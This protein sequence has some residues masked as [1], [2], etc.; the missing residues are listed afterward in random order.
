MVLPS[1]RALSHSGAEPVAAENNKVKLGR[2]ELIQPWASAPASIHFEN[3]KGF[4]H[5]VRCVREITVSHWGNIYFEETF[6]LHNAG[7]KHKGAFSRLKYQYGSL[8][9]ANSF[10]A[11]R[12]HLPAGAHSLYYKDLIG[13]ISSSN[14]RKASN[15]AGLALDLEPRYPLMGGWKVDFFVGYSLPLGNGVLARSSKS[16][17]YRLSLP[18]SAAM[19][20]VSID[21]LVVRVVLP[22]GAASIKAELPFG[23]VEQGRDKVFSYLDTVGRPVLVLTKRGMVPEHMGAEMVVEYSFS[24]SALWR[25]GLLLVAAFATLFALLIAT[26][27]M[28][29]TISKDARWQEAQQKEVVAGKKGGRL[30]DTAA[31]KSVGALCAAAEHT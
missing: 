12:L 22:E 10:S 15:F 4:K 27:R 19:E 3:A 20:E 31:G 21:E 8:G 25:K 26:N 14:V 29:F 1:K 17:K 11:V 24:S 2:Y 30:P 6:E 13:N 28:E 23:G 9:K 18:M 7:A 16:G 5:V